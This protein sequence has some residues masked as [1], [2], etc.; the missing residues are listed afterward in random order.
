MMDIQKIINEKVD[1]LVTE[2]EIK[3]KIES[4]IENTIKKSIDDLLG[5]YSFRKDIENKL[6]KHIDPAL[7]DL[8][9]TVYG[10]M[11]AQR[12]SAIVHDVMGKDLSEKVD[13]FYNDL[14]NFK[15]SE[16][17][18]KLS[19]ILEVAREY[20]QE[21]VRDSSYNDEEEM[22]L[23]IEEDT[24]HGLWDIGFQR[25]EL[26]SYSSSREKYS[27]ENQMTLSKSSKKIIVDGEELE[28]YWMLSVNLDRIKFNF[29]DK[30]ISHIGSLNSYEALILN[31]Y[32]NKRPIIM[33]VT[34]KSDV[35]TYIGTDYDY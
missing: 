19:E 31:A 5:G 25:E 16:E 13:K 12:F 7:E 9:L 28:T 35:E 32:F 4:S 21:E 17:P 33:D 24:Y 10:E 14:F 8:D 27:Y 26:P 34:Y 29:Q 1:S 2:G 11:I 23:L 30:T 20:F 18:L 22:Q 15:N 6:K 3:E